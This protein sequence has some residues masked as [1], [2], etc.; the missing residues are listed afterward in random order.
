MNKKMMLL[1][2][3]GWGI[4]PIKERSAI[5]M[6]NTPNFN[7]LM[8][9]YPNAT[10]LT[11]GENVGLPEG[12]MGN[13]EV[14]H[15]NIGAGRVIYQELARINKAVREGEL[16]AN[17]LL[18]EALREAVK[19][20]ASIHL[21]GLVSDGGVHSHIDHL[22]ALCTLCQDMEIPNTFVH[23]FLDGRDTDPKSG[24]GYLTT[25]QEKIA[26]S[27]VKLATAIGRYYAMDR[28]N[29]WE[30]T[31]KAYDLLVYGEGSET[32]D[33]LADLQRS[34][35]EGITDEFFEPHVAVTDNAARIKDQD[36]VIF[37]NFR[38]DR[39]RQLTRVLTQEPVEEYEL[40]PLNIDMITFARYDETFEGIDVLFEKDTVTHS[41][42]EVVADA[43]LSQLRIAETEKYPHVSFFF[44]GGR[45]EAFDKE[46]RILVPSPKVATYD[47]EPEM[48]ARE[49][50]DKLIDF[51]EKNAPDFVC[52]NFANTD[53]VGHTGVFSAAIK[54]AETVD[55]CLGKIIPMGL[56]KDY[57]FI[58]IADHG[59]SDYMINDDGSP[60][61]AHTTNPVPVIYVAND[62]AGYSMQNGILA[63]VAP[64]ILHCMGVAPSKE[65]NGKVLLS[66]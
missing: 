50:T 8:A 53:M 42:G 58:I 65:M 37:F 43:G 55:E 3:D 7:A 2:L 66:K 22:M 13:S 20:N 31:K 1:I 23:A 10:L 25:L 52:L 4:G 26:D 14:G 63:D 16:H 39:P 6:A 48:S 5:A 54:A 21:M 44:S 12:Q 61:T 29:R 11:H 34:Y 35:D 64:T 28:D 19:R 9:K 18:H 46:S 24:L 51:V 36:L 27:N 59:N 62:A 32:T 33:L 17:P 49:I 47:L 45:E 57:G 56:E 60:N 40:Y 30:R 41:L 15:I 38:T